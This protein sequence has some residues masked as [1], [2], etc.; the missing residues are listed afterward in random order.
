ML[1]SYPEA[2]FYDSKNT[3]FDWTGK[4][5]EATEHILEKY[6]DSSDPETVKLTWQRFLTGWQH[7]AAFGRYR[8]ISECLRGSLD[9]ALKYHDIQGDSSDADY[10]IEAWDDVYPFTDT[11]EALKRQQELT[12][13]IIFSN[14]ESKYLRMMVDKMDGFEPDLLATMQDA[15]AIKPNPRAYQ[16]VLDEMGLAKDDVLYAAGPIWDLNG[17]SAYGLQCAH[18][19][20]PET[21]QPANRELQFEPAYVVDDLSEVTALL[22]AGEITPP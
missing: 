12:D 6:G 3:L 9:D 19:S 7:R 11:V 15:R 1:N 8:D 5:I 10:M 16:W 13:V 14:V 4:W 17:A 22:E 20:R 2:I 21:S 18:I